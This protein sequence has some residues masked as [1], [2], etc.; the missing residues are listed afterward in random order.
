MSDVGP[1]D[2]EILRSAFSVGL[3]WI[4]EGL[5]SNCTTVHTTDFGSTRY[6]QKA[7]L[8]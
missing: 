2:K 6:G 3:F 4:E 1:R 8:H 5:R 7:V